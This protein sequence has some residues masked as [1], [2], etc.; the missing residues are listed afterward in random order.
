MM[1]MD[2]VQS[3]SGNIDVQIDYRGQATGGGKLF[4]LSMIVND[5]GLHKNLK[6]RFRGLVGQ[7]IQLNDDGTEGDVI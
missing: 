6:I 7:I 2:V 1:S 5:P 3:W 4:D